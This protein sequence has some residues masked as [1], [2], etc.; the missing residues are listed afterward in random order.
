MDEMEKRLKRDAARIRARVPPD[1]S[2]RVQASLSRAT[3]PGRPTPRTIS[4]GLWLAASLSG[5]AAA[6]LLLLLLP[7]ADRSPPP[8]PLARSVPLPRSIAG[9]FP[10]EVKT[11]E[12]TA[13]LEQELDNLQSDIEKAREQVKEDLDF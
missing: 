12:L 3:E 10:L 9:E 11:A 7:H 5:A 2:A 13:P 8:E 1:V 6:A 4:L